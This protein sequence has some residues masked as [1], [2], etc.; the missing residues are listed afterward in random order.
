MNTLAA[1]TFTSES[2]F[3]QN[4]ANVFKLVIKSKLLWQ[5]LCRRATVNVRQQWP[6]PESPIS[7]FSSNRYFIPSREF[8]LQED[9]VLYVY[10]STYVY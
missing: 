6:D 7:V 5:N 3:I 9:W 8:S 4:W 1:D 2:I 10:M